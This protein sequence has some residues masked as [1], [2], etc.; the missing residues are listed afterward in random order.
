MKIKLITI[1]IIS[2]LGLNA[3]NH[4]SSS[5]ND[6]PVQTNVESFTDQNSNDQSL[7]IADG[8]LLKSDLNA[9]FGNADD[10]P[11]AVED[12]DSVQDVIDR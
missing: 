2:L 8:G 6:N 11:K 5:N 10:E 12:S 9:L 3:C 7:V 4:G 1:G